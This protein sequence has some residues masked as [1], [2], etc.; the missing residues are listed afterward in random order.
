M[1]RNTEQTPL[2]TA[3]VRL[4]RIVLALTALGTAAGAARLGVW[5]A[6][7]FL[8]GGLGGWLNLRLIERAAD[9]LMGLAVPSEGQARPSRPSGTALLI[10]FTALVLGA[11][12]IIR[13]SGFNAQAAVWG[14]FTLPAAVLLEILYELTNFKN[15]K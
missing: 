2:E 1:S 14:F 6:G 8:A 7:G 10:Q 5:W 11:F 12:V 4:P 15:E 13:Y 9:R 3:M